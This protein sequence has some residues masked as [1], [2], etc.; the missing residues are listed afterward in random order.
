MLL[1]RLRHESRKSL[2]YRSH[3]KIKHTVVDLVLESDLL[4]V[5]VLRHSTVD[6][7]H[8]THS[9]PRE[10]SRTCK[11]SVNLFLAQAKLRPHTCEDGLT[12]DRCKRHTETVKGNPVDLLLP[13][14]PTP[15]RTGVSIC[16][17]V[18]IK[19]VAE[20]RCH[21]LARHISKLRREFKSVTCPAGDTIAVLKYEIIKTPAESD[22]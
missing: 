15:E 8:I 2:I 3:S 6:R 5:P 12:S 19:T 1:H 7:C 4:L 22:S 11:I 10:V 20:R 17:N 14:F 21:A 18:V 16:T 9:H 13:L